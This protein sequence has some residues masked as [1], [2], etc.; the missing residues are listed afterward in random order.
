LRLDATVVDARDMLVYRV[1]V[2]DQAAIVDLARLLDW[3]GSEFAHRAEAR[4]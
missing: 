4:S 2:R 1:L 3:P